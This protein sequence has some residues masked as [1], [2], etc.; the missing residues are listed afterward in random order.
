MVVPEYPAEKVKPLREQLGMTQAQLAE[1]LGVTRTLVTHWENNLRTPSGPA[2]VLLEQLE[3]KAA[4]KTPR[5]G[6]TR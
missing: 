3:R 1:H 4:K 5:R 6:L 2:A